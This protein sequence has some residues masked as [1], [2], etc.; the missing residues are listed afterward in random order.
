MRRYS[1]RLASL[2]Q[3]ALE[4]RSGSSSSP[5]SE[6]ER[7]RMEPLINLAQQ[8]RDLPRLE[9]SESALDLCLARLQRTTR[10]ENRRLSSRRGLVLAFASTVLVLLIAAGGVA[11]A[12]ARSSLPGEMLYPV[13]R[14]AEDV[15]LFLT[16]NPE[17]KVEWYV[18]LS[19]RR[20][21][22]FVTT[23]KSG[24]VRTK[25]LN[26]MLKTTQCAQAT[27]ERAAD[28]KREALV[29]QIGE[30]CLNQ[31]TVL[32][33]MKFIVSGKDTALINAAIAQCAMC[34]KSCQSCPAEIQCEPGQERH[35][36]FT[37]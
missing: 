7:Q 1:S 28:S 25:T 23:A 36:E 17:G 19:Q 14:C 16:R 33:G 11:V 6:D 4:R 22:E 8:L 21:D 10:Q 31:G 2:L 30:L 34:S 27:V 3:A 13:K 29:A 5:L 26:A 37:P 32:Q 9:P 35:L 12:T 20:L 15:R 18:C 24:E